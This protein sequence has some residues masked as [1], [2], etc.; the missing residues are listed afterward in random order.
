MFLVRNGEPIGTLYGYVEDGFYDNEAEVRAD[1]YYRNET[2]SK[3]K[4]MVGEVKI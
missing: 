4:S 1:P 2:D 3:V